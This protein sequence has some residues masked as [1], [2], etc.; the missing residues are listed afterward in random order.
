[1]TNEVSNLC[2]EQS[3]SSLGEILGKWFGSEEFGLILNDDDV[4]PTINLIIL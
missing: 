4:A 3:T 2:S 1:M